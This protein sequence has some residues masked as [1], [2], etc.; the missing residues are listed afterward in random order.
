[1]TR[2]NFQEPFYTVEPGR[3]FQVLMVNHMN[4]SGQYPL[5]WDSSSNSERHRGL[6]V[7]SMALE[8]YCQ[9]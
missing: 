5:R 7:Q 2:D 1:M 4:T 3:A 6:V 8:L 9:A